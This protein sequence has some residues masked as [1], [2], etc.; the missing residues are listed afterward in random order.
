M[1]DV[2]MDVVAKMTTAER[3]RAE[4]ISALVDGELMHAEAVGSAGMVAS[5]VRDDG[6][7]ARWTRYQNIGDMLR[8]ADLSPTSR[9][10]AFMTR[11]RLSL[12]VEPVVVAPT[13]VP[14]ASADNTAAQGKERQVANGN[15]S[16]G[17]TRAIGLRAGSI[18][19]LPLKAI[20]ALGIAVVAGAFAWK[21]FAPGRA[22]PS[23]APVE[24]GVSGAAP[25]G[26]LVAVNA[27]QAA[28]P[29]SNNS[30]AGLVVV[31]TANGAV[32]R[33][34]RLDQYFAAHSRVRSSGLGDGASMGAPA[35][36]VRNASIDSAAQQQ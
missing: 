3:E 29:S 36:F 27:K 15:L 18:S 23:A 25:A 30:D 10:E 20:A 5:V 8:S 2:K 21:A 13:A 24:I 14:V 7:V 11:M 22:A 32:I 9:D 12:A 16:L 35:A 31:Q 17:S 4:R 34:A 26:G 28:S 1:T 19:A 33:D 6:A